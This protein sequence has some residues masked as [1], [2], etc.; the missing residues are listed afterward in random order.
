MICRPVPLI[1]QAT[2]AARHSP[3][4]TNAFA[5]SNKGS[6]NSDPDLVSAGRGA[7][8]AEAVK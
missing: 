4:L 3:Y 6:T 2:A 5:R 8:G 1:L 7:V